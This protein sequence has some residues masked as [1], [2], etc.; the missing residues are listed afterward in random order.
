M[1]EFKGPHWVLRIKPRSCGYKIRTLTSI[2]PLQFFS[3][4]SFKE[5]CNFWKDSPRNAHEISMQLP[6]ILTKPGSM[7]LC[8]D[9]VMVGDI[10][11]NL[12]YVAASRDTQGDNQR[13][14]STGA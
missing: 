6:M 2:I 11:P 7:T 9:L 14:C 1:E 5:F 10:G 12:L 8:L 3:H 4:L 13:L